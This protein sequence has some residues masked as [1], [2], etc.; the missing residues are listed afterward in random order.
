MLT[1]KDGLYYYGDYL[2]IATASTKLGQVPSGYTTHVE[3]DTLVFVIDGELYEGIVIDVCGACMGLSHENSQRIDVL[4][5][6]SWLKKGFIY[7]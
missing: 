7:D 6:N 1:L 5:T 4:S 3:S 2:A